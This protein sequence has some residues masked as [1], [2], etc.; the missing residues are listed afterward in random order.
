MSNEINNYEHSLWSWS[1]FWRYVMAC[2]SLKKHT[3]I[4]FELLTSKHTHTHTQTWPAE[5]IFDSDDN[6]TDCWAVHELRPETKI[7]I[8]I[9]LMYSCNGFNG[10]KKIFYIGKWIKF[11]FTINNKMIK[12]IFVKEKKIAYIKLKLMKTILLNV[13]MIV[14][15]LGMR[16]NYSVNTNRVTVWNQR[17]KA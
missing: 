3:N 9:N 14:T 7:P 2:G 17:P 8:Y 6:K 5:S 4:F 10:F 12:I 13:L 1:T 11:V 15:A 16:R